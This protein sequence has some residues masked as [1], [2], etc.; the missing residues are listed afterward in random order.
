MNGAIS[1]RN[2]LALG[3]NLFKAFWQAA[4]ATTR[5][6]GG[7]GLG[8]YI[9][10]QLAELLGGSVW[11]HS[12]GPNGSVFKLKLPQICLTGGN[13][14]IRTSGVWTSVPRVGEKEKLISERSGKES[15][16]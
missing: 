15:G 5:A 12:S 14:R 7:A 4:D 6:A 2:L 1:K 16:R 10:R 13:A 8:L 11:L 9:C 3:D